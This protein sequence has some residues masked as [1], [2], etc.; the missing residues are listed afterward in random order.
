MTSGELNK[1]GGIDIT[2]QNNYCIRTVAKSTVGIG[3][4]KTETTYKPRQRYF[5]A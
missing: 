4:L 3:V 2:T 1:I 5:Y